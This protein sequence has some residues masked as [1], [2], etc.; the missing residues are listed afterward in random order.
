MAFWP[1]PHQDWNAGPYTTLFVAG[2]TIP[3]LVL[4]FSTLYSTAPCVTRSRARSIWLMFAFMLSIAAWA[5]CVVSKKRP[6]GPAP[7]PTVGCIRPS[8]VCAMPTA[9]P[10]TPSGP[11]A[12]PNAPASMLNIT[13]W[14]ALV[15]S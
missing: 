12:L 9:A 4:R 3:G 2:S 5:A 1:L 7:G 14:L 6:M 8:S 13:W 10:G 11:G 15:A